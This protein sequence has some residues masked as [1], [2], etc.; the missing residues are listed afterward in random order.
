MAC[1]RKPG[2]RCSRR[3]AC[4]ERGRWPA[5]FPGPSVWTR[6]CVWRVRTA[7]PDVLTVWG[8]ESSGLARGT[9]LA[10]WASW[11]LLTHQDVRPPVDGDPGGLP[12]GT[13]REVVWKVPSKTPDAPRAWRPVGESLFPAGLC[14]ST[15]LL[16]GQ[17][18][19]PAGRD[20]GEASL[21]EAGA[22]GPPVSVRDLMKT[23]PVPA[24]LG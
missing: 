14:Q 16:R 8:A 7:S 4:R 22:R 21:E 15:G 2:P 19:G 13:Q 6:P 17:L 10:T 23:A 11:S 3:G 18:L 20:A 12:A 9:Q 1:E 24:R 5:A